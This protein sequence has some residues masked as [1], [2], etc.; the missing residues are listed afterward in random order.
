MK[1]LFGYYG[2][3]Q[4]MASKIVPLLPRHTVYVEPFCGGASVFFK[5]PRPPATNNDHYRE[6]LN[7]IDERIIN[8]Y[9][10]VQD[11]KSFNEFQRIV[12]VPYARSEYIRCSRLLL[13]GEVINVP[14]VNAAAA[15]W[16]SVKQSFAAK[17]CGGWGVNVFSRNSAIVWARSLERLPEYL[18]CM[19]GVTLES[20]DALAVIDTWD[21]PQTLFYCDPPYPG[22]DQ[23]C[24][25][26]YTQ[27]QFAALCD[28]LD[29]CKGSFV[30]SCYD[31]HAV[32][33]TWECYSFDTN[34]GAIGGKSKANRKRTERVWRVD[35]SANARPEIHKI[36]EKWEKS[37]FAWG[38]AA[39]KQ[40]RLC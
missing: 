11:R 4:R 33:D 20:R 29:T 7:D 6:V 19:L 5:K 40:E 28:K 12:S 25:K 27:A 14:D 9:R 2:G 10:V 39:P 16:I 18:D 26:G 15:Y 30:L 31:N 22:T 37:G 32:P 17:P 24:Y 13:G 3:K 35:R 23:G 1:P 36:W 38:D 8:L 21:S 34:I